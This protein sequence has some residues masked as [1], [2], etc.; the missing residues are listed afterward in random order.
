MHTK[1]LRTTSL[2][3]SEKGRSCV[4]LGG[5]KKDAKLVGIIG[6]VHTKPGTKGQNG[7]VKQAR[8]RA[9]LSYTVAAT[10]MWQFTA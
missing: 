10:H 2:Q 1:S 6:E 9:A 7:T 3:S 8:S 5:R 4:R